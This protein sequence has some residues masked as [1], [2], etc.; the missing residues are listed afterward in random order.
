MFSLCII[1]HLIFHE[2][3]GQKLYPSAWLTSV[4]LSDT[5]SKFN[6]YHLSFAMYNFIKL[7]LYRQIAIHAHI[8]YLVFFNNYVILL[9]LPICYVIEYRQ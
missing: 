6:L 2:Y 5:S 1:I 9:L 3:I 7:S 8:H 4:I